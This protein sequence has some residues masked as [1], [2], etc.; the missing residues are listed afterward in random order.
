M[1]SNIQIQRICLHCGNEFIAKTTVTKFCSQKCASKNYKKRQ[2]EQKLESSNKEKL[3]IKTIPVLELKE[4]SFLSIKEVCTLTGISRTTLWRMEVNQH[5]N[6]T[7]FNRRKLYR[8]DDIDR[9]FKSERNAQE[10]NDN[11]EEKDI[12]NYRLD[13]LYSLS[14]VYKLYKVKP[15]GLYQILKRNNVPKKRIGK[16]VFVP[17]EDIIKIFNN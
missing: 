17:M 10:T 11:V 3:E 6:P 2:R 9:L 5:L 14:Q 12:N 15:E 13:E 16:E 8:R 1:S 7:N 4:K